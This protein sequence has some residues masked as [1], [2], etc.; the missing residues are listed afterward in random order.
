M[1]CKNVSSDLKS[2]EGGGLLPFDSLPLG[3]SEKGLPVTGA[4]IVKETSSDWEG[5]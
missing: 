5:V 3:L 2:W 4:A 1:N